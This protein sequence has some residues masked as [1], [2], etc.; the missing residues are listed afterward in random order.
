MD[1]QKEARKW[2]PNSSTLVQYPISSHLV[3][4]LLYYISIGS[5][6][7][8]LTSPFTTQR[9]NEREG[10]KVMC[11]TYHAN[12][13]IRNERVRENSTVFSDRAGVLNSTAIPFLLGIKGRSLEG[14]QVDKAAMSQSR[15]NT[16]KHKTEL[17]GKLV[18]SKER[19]NA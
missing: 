13:S 11:A 17:I 3:V 12:E 16:S 7:L 9:R 18:L 10:R 14:Q 15:I 2:D 4:S 5:Y 19:R 8:V 1:V 6:Q